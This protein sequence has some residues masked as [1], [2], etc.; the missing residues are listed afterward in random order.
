MK[1]VDGLDLVKVQ[2]KYKYIKQILST[3]LNFNHILYIYYKLLLFINTLTNGTEQ[4][5][6]IYKIFH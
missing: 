6:N 3:D 1:F 4:Q 5:A 2:R